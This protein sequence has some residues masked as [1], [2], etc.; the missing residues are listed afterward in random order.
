MIP[1]IPY[2]SL[3]ST[4]QSTAAKEA[5]YID[6]N[7]EADVGEDR[8]GI[9]IEGLFWLIDNECESNFGER[10]SLGSFM[11]G[12]SRIARAPS[13]RAPSDQASLY[14]QMGWPQLHPVSDSTETGQLRQV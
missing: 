10:Q 2:V 7:R 4:G 12:R 11:R 3:G 5:E 9:S 1:T 13:G 6:R 14:Q 8:N